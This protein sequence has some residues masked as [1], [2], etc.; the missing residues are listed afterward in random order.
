M[1][2]ANILLAG[3]CNL[4]CPACIGHQLGRWAGVDTL[5]TFPLP[6]LDAFVAALDRLA[7][8]EVSVTGVN[9][10]PL[11]YR[12]T[13]SL[14]E[15]LRLE[16][17]DLRLSLHTNGRLAVA[18]RDLVHLYDRAT[19]SLPSFSSTTT[20]A[21]TGSWQVLDLAA[22]VRAIHLPLK[23]SILVTEHNRAELPAILARCVDLGLR[24]AVLR[25]PYG[26]RGPWQPLGAV[27]PRT[28]FGGNPVVTVAGME[29]TLWDFARTELACLNL[30]PDGTL[31]GDYQ[32][33]VGAR[34]SA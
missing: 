5:D 1:D 33:A 16:L 12:P 4:R 3:P 28:C 17:P 6:G 19:I 24:R 27:A 30:R 8:R 14:V 32:L 26:E 9:T 25:R 2:F 23:V 13:Q 18:R 15:R 10:D 11:L 29:V 34:R 7:I 22:I 31:D 20:H 21:M